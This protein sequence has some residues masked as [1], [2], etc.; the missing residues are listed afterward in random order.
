MFPSDGEIEHVVPTAEGA[1]AAGAVPAD[2]SEVPAA[3]TQALWMMPLE[4][5]NGLLLELATGFC[6]QRAAAR[7]VTL[8]LR[9]CR[10]AG[11]PWA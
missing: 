6:L 3:V 1:T 10:T 8:D 11:G 5:P 2:K 4:D 7:A 9:A